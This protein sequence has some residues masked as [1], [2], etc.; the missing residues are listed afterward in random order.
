[1][2]GTYWLDPGASGAFEAYCDMTT[3]GGGWTLVAVN[4]NNPTLT[5][6]TGAMGQVAQI[7]PSDPGA[8]VIHKLSDA[9]INQIKA[10]NG[11]AV[12]VRLIFEGTPSLTKFGKAGCTWESDSR[13]PADPDCDYA[14]GAYSTNPAWTGPATS[15][16]FSGGLPSWSLGAC[17][18]W[19]RMGIYSSA[20]NNVPRSLFHVGGCTLNSWGTLWVR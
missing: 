17:P 2:S 20:Y 1:M 10:D 16:W 14:T 19:E 11:D 6:A 13:N 8:D 15:Y 3:D 18:S 5:M 9:T 12:G 4:G 7:V